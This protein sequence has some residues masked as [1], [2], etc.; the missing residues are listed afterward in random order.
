VITRGRGRGAI[1]LALPPE[2]RNNALFPP[3]TPPTSGPQCSPM[4]M[5][6]GLPSGA[7]IVAHSFCISSA[8]HARACAFS[9][10]VPP[11]PARQPEAAM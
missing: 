11:S 3:T 9:S 4:R 7:Q 6:T 10:S 8:R 2:S 5:T 1:Q